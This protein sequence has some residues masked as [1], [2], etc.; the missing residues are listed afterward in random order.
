MASDKN[1]PTERDQ[2]RAGF[3]AKI[4]AWTA[5]LETY[6][7]ATRI[8]GGVSEAVA[9]AV[10]SATNAQDLPV[11]VFRGKGVKEAIVIYLEAT[12][13]KQTNKEIAAGLE[14]GGIATTSANFESTV[15]T[16][17]MRLRTDGL[18][19]RF[20]DGWDLA[21]QYPESLRNRLQKDAPAKR[22]K[23]GRKAKPTAQEPKLR[24]ITFDKISEA[25]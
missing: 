23:G 9:G 2:I 3:V 5:V 15:A 18:V 11:G 13:R 10:F 14:A 7:K 24:G 1:K 21:A 19:L 6:D 4:A 20:P 8:D 16:A 25:S 17:L 22:K 12:R